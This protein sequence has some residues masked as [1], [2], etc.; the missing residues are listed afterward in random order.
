MSGEA[1]KL[2]SLLQANTKGQI[3]VQNVW[4]ICTSVDWHA[5]TMECKGVVDNLEY[6][7]VLLGIG[8][9]YIKPV[10]GTKCLIGLIQNKSAA[11]FI[12]YAEEIEEYLI[13]D[14]TGF[15]FHLN[16]GN[17]T[18][19]GD[20]FGSMIK[21]EELVQKV[22]RLENKLND[23]VAKYNAHIH[24]TTATVGA[25]ATPG[26]IAPTTTTETPISPLT[27]VSDLENPKIK[28]G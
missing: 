8:H 11:A 9:K 17:L 2:R 20:E 28:H 16:E 21:I 27:A 25:S 24:I 15:K 10:V 19:N 14:K 4:V 7:D 18:I 26:T 22:N 3:P 13:E 12:I 6:F 1:D 23:L 5:K